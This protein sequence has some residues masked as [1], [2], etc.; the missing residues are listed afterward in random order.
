[1]AHEL[2]REGSVATAELLHLRAAVHVARDDAVAALAAC[3]EARAMLLAL[4]ETRGPVA[5]A[6]AA[7]RGAVLDAL[8]RYPEA[9][10]DIRQAVALWQSLAPDGY[11]LHA[12]LLARLARLQSLQGDVRDAKAT[13]L[14]ALTL[15]RQRGEIDPAALATLR[16]LVT[17]PHPS[18]E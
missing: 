15:I 17:A 13:A 5:I 16:S 1:M 14:S 9:L 10:A 4:G 7:Q 12:E 3:D 11:R 6:V 2:F 8:Q 18:G